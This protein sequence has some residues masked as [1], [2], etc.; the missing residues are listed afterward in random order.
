MFFVT[1]FF[2]PEKVSQIKK[3][4]KKTVMKN[5]DQDKVCMGKK[6]ENLLLPMFFCVGWAF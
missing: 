1:I 4:V 5:P 2:K 3:K 6:K